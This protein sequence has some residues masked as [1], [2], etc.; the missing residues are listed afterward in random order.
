MGGGVDASVPGGRA[1]TPNSG[2]CLTPMTVAI[3]WP[4]RNFALPGILAPTLIPLN[5][6]ATPHK[7]P[8]LFVPIAICDTNDGAL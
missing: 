4:E 6:A 8:A 2:A 1:L 7:I 5:L 3:I